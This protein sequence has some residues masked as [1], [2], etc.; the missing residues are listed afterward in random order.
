VN[1]RYAMGYRGHGG[2]WRIL[3]L[4]YARIDPLLREPLPETVLAGVAEGRGA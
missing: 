2:E 1:R 3:S 4:R